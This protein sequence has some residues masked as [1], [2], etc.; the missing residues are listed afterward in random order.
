MAANMAAETQVA[1]YLDNYFTYNV[2][3]GVKT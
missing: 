2:D 3:I 1:L